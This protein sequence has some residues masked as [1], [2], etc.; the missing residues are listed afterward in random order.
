MKM[1]Q[2][3]KYTGAILFGLSIFLMLDASPA[4]IVGER[5]RYWGL[6]NMPVWYRSFILKIYES[7]VLWLSM[8]AEF[9]AGSGLFLMVRKLIKREDL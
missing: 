9:M 2:P 6:E 4:L 3:G 8:L 7:P 1:M 5:Y